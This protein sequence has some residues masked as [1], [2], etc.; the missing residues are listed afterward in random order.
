L[1][2]YCDGPKVYMH[3]LEEVL[4]QVLRKFGLSGM[5]RPGMPGVWIQDRKIAAMGVRI[6][7]GVTRH[8]FALNVENDLAPFSEIVPC[9]L[10]GYEV[11]S[12]AS[13]GLA[14]ASVTMA[15]EAVVQTFQTVFGIAL[16]RGHGEESLSNA[17]MGSH[18][19]DCAAMGDGYGRA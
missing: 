10:L 13:E 8:G 1:R 17:I 11:T 18:R 5:R 16:A 7:N 19:R 15:K 3:M 4:I 9:G 6:S 14:S 2:T 12:M